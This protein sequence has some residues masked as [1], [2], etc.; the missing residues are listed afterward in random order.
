MN[1]LSIRMQIILSTTV[2]LILLA[3]ITTNISVSQSKE[4]LI[5]NSFSQLTTVRDMKKHFIESFFSERVG[6]INVLS[7]S[8]NLYNIV[9]DLLYV[10]EE[11]KVKATDRYPVENEITKEATAKHEE[12]FQG[13]MKDYGYYD[14]FIICAKHG[15]VLYSTAKESD[16][17][18]NITHGSLKDS[19]LAEAYRLALKNER[20]LL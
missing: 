19:G 17:G 11:L 2:S 13:Y 9:N 12:F 4:A 16:Y 3:L 14:V 1:K 7:R 8:E 5:K 20:L 15:H 18:A 10:H 6:D